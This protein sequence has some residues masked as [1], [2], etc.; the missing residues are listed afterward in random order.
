MKGFEKK[1][2]KSARMV[3]KMVYCKKKH[4]ENNTAI[5]DYGHDINNMT[6]EVRLWVDKDEVHTEV[7]KYPD[8]D[9]LKEYGISKVVYKHI[10][11]LSKGVFPEKMAYERG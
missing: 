2:K 8:K 9:Q 6:G 3:K 1:G 10:D 4:E 7:S 5:Y 11:T